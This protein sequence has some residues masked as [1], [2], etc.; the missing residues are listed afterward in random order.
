MGLSQTDY[1]ALSQYLGDHDL[2]IQPDQSVD[3]THG[4]VPGVK[5]ILA[6]TP[7]VIAGICGWLVY[8]GHDVGVMFRNKNDE[9]TINLILSG[10]DKSKAQGSSGVYIQKDGDA[11]Q[12][13]APKQLEKKL[14]EILK[15]ESPPSTKPAPKKPA[16]K[17]TKPS[18]SPKKP[19]TKTKSGSRGEC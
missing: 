12:V 13:I 6:L 19:G 2:P 5:I 9:I 7:A 3:T 8:R 14:N 16:P 18:H 10:E 15:D 17:K 1:A 11:Y 4:E